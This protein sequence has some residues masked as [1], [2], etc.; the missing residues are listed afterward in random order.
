MTALRWTILLI[1]LATGIMLGVAWSSQAGVAWR[2]NTVQ[3]RVYTSSAWVPLIQRSVRDINAVMPRKGPRLILRVHGERSC[4]WVRKQKFTRPT[5]TI[6]S[7]PD[8]D[9]LGWTRYKQQ[10]HTFRHER[11]RIMLR[12]EPNPH[13]AFVGD[14][15]NTVCH[16]L[17]HAVSGMPDGERH[18][19]S[20][21][22]GW[23]ESP[24]P[25]DVAYLQ[26]VYRKR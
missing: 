26:R 14:D 5:I 20:C 11:V 7:R 3:V 9:A 19:D 22:Q 8:R 12:G 21:V 25:W 13:P 6:C 18:A 17:M 15:Q 24:G 4:A 23:L 10:R 1:G 16:E 2:S